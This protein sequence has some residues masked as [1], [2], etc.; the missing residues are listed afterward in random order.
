MIVQHIRIIIKFPKIL[1]ILKNQSIFIKIITIYFMSIEVYA[2][3][4]IVIC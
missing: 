4:A 1:L 3:F 2:I